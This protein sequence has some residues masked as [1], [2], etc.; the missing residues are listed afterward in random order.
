MNQNL[1]FYFY[2]ILLQFL[3]MS[4]KYLQMLDKHNFG[5]LKIFAKLYKINKFN[6]LN[7][8]IKKKKSDDIPVY[9]KLAT[10]S[11]VSKK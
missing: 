4:I 2:F 6:Y 1:I 9:T 11:K 8:I 5:M 7:I 3:T 10:Y